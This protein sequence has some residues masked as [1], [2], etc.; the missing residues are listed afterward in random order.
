MRTLDIKIFSIGLLVILSS[1][2]LAQQ[3]QFQPLPIDPKVKYGKLENGLTYYI[4]SNQQPKNRADFYIVQN[5]GAILENDD[6]TD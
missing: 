6:Q 3:T 4:R 1:S 2:V 5:V